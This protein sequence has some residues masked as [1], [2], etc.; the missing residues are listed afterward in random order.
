LDLADDSGLIELREKTI[1]LRLL[2]D[3]RAHESRT[4]IQAVSVITPLLLIGV[5]A[6]SVWLVRKR[7]YI[8]S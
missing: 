4:L 3:K 2:N 5:L 6:I 8:L 1:A 7:K